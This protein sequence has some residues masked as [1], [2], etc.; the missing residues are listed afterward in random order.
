MLRSLSNIARRRALIRSS[1]TRKICVHGA[2]LAAV[3]ATLLT[4][5]RA[6]AQEPVSV[7]PGVYALMGRGGVVTP[8]NLGRVANVA[9]V[10]GPRGVVVVDSGVSLRQGQ[11]IIAAVRQ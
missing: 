10:V 8:E 4:C 9:F 5:A 11:A 1:V 3:L 2:L 7:A 6:T